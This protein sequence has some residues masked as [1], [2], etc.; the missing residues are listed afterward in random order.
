[1]NSTPTITS[2]QLTVRQQTLIEKTEKVGSL[3]PI[4]FAK[5]VLEHNKIRTIDD[6]ELGPA[7]GFIFQNISL[8]IGVKSQISD[9]N[10]KDIRNMIVKYYGNL[11]LEEIV[12]AFE[13]ERYNQLEPKTEHFQLFN[14]EYVS[15]VLKKYKNWLS[16]IRFDNNL[17]MSIEKPKKPSLSES[18]KQ[19]ILKKGCIRCF[20]E[21]KSTGT[22]KEGNTH[23]YEFLI[24]EKALKSFSIEQKNA[25]IKIAKEKI[26]L[27]AKSLGL[28]KGKE[29]IKSLENKNNKSVINKAKSLLLE[30]YFMSLG[31][32]HL[33][34]ILI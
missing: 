11:S 13:L 23:I 30:S 19:E 10:K 5:N 25:A 21:Y 33:K 12:Y 28:V 27:Q 24:D 31:N 18:E 4:A 16:Q 6:S 17:P 22:V 7:I 20:N 2:Q 26:K 9:I 14:A 34:D 29:I 3:S 8:L 1:M 15:T 32:K